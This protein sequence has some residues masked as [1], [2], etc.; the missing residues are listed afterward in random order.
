LKDGF[1]SINYSST[2]DLKGSGGL[3]LLLSFTY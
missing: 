1:W 3:Y 2:C